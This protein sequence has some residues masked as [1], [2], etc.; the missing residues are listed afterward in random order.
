MDL[1]ISCI[2]GLLV[3]GVLGGLGMT[4]IQQVRSGRIQVP[5][6]VRVGPVKLD[7]TGLAPQGEAAKGADAVDWSNM[8]P[9]L[10]TGGS[11][12]SGCLALAGAGL[13][14]VGFLLPW[15]TCSIPLLM[16]GSF[17]GFSMLVQLVGGVLLS[18]L[19]VLGGDDFAALSGVLALILIGV[20]AVLIIIPLMGLRVGSKGLQLIQSP[21]VSSQV[22]R[23]TSRTLIRTA[24]IGFIPMLCYL[25][26]A[27]AQISGLGFLGV[28]VQSA[29]RGLWV[30]LGGFGLAI[31][32]GLV[33][34]TTAAWAEQMARPGTAPT[35]SPPAVA[36]PAPQRTQLTEEERRVLGLIAEGLSN[37]EIAE[38]LSMSP[39]NASLITTELQGFFG[40]PSRGELVPTARARGYLPPVL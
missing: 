36:S 31:V 24:I 7:L 5:P 11:L 29:D 26:S 14:L 9:V 37:V 3:G 22:R 25:T 10:E 6:E 2:L 18:A 19:G 8:R 40:V 27:T 21:R 33:I 15:F 32:A 28:S 12:T 34:S 4:L 35:P 20:T 1:A 30:T 16:S 13:V 38:R 23:E 39:V 17:S